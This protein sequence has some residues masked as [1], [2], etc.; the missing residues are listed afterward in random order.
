MFGHTVS[1]K[2]VST[3]PINIAF[4]FFCVSP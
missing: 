4:N 3:V 1:G 2:S